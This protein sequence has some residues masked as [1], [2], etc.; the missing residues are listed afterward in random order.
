[1]FIK[2]LDYL[3][4]PIT[5]Y[6]KGSLSH[7]SILSGIISIISIIIII[8]IAIY[9]LLDLMQRKSPNSFYFNSFVEDSG[10]FPL[11]ASSLF[12]FISIATLTNGFTN[13]GVD[14]TNFRIIG[15]ENYFE[16]YLYD[17]N[18]SK[19]DHWLYGKCNNESD[20]TGIKYLINFDFFEKSACIRKYFNSLEK[21]Y[22]DTW[23]SNFR[24]PEIA[25]GTYNE[26]VKTYS[27]FFEKCKD[28]TIDLILGEEGHCKEYKE[29]N[30]SF[31]NLRILNIYFINN[32]IN[33]LNYNNPNI[34]F[35]YRIESGIYKNQYT[36]NHLNFNPSKLQTHNGFIFDNIDE[37][38]S[39]FFDRNDAFIEEN[40]GDDIFMGYCFWLKNTMH[41]YE[42]HY[43]RIQDIFSS[44]GGI[45]QVVT[46]IAIYINSLYNNYIILSDSENLLNS[47]IH[48]EKN[49][50]IKKE[51]D[52][53]KNNK[54]NIIKSSEREKYKIDNINN[55]NEKIHKEQSAS[56]NYLNYPANY[57]N[58]NMNSNIKEKTED[59]DN[60][61]NKKFVNKKKEENKNFMKYILYKLTCE[62]KDNCFKIYNNFRKKLISEEHL[63]RNHLN[64]Y[65]L[66]RI[67]ERKRS[68]RRNSY[69][70]NDLIKL[71]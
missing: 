70:L 66:L 41:Y 68:S 2:N 53:K 17:K 58:N 45:Y 67:T 50:H 59:I 3:S 42:R 54:K 40:K 21:K 38:H 43:K 6:H 25:H 49:I 57:E 34:K 46:I 65:N 61:Q 31:N 51:N 33:V 16:T 10:I 4:P 29:I 14:F 60:K 36:I 52:I 11:N 19:Y 27:I 26:K 22:Y 35:F 44:I 56:T 12:H 15:Y 9:F 24:W 64:I 71:I 48:I 63:I 55:K 1:M 69:Q 39:L 5:F 7:S 32:Y 62:S 13:E 37:Y 30:E 23:E 28:D 47:L 20:T 18:I 8:I